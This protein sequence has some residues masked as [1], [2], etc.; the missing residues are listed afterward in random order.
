M[1]ENADQLKCIRD[2]CCWPPAGKRGVG[3]SRANLFGK[4]FDSYSKEAQSPILVAMIENIEA[5]DYLEEILQVDGLDA[6][7]IGPYDL[8][9]S[10]ALTG[11]FDHPDFIDVLD[12]VLSLSAAENIPCGIHIINPLVDELKLRIEEG[13]KFIAY[14]IDSVFLNLSAIRPSL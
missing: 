6:I 8:S 14:S 5:V 3:F 1:I 2:A 10:M 11:K 9:A 12:K 13:C 4:Y 7:L